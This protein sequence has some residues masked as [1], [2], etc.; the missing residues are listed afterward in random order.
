MFLFEAQVNRHPAIL[1]RE[2]YNIRD[3]LGGFHQ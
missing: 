2:H 3:T 1:L